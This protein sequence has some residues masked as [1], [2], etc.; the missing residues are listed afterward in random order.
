MGGRSP[1]REKISFIPNALHPDFARAGEPFSSSFV[2]PSRYLL[3]IASQDRPHK[4]LA[5][6]LSI[7]RNLG[8]ARQNVS[9]VIAGQGVRDVGNLPDGVVSRGVVSRSE[10]SELYRSAAGVVIPSRAEGFGFV[11][12]EAHAHGVR[13]L[14][15]PVPALLELAGEGDLVCEDSSE[16]SLEDG[17]VR[18]LATLE[19]NTASA[20]LSAR[21][22]LPSF[23]R[24]MAR[25][26]R[27]VV[28]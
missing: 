6:L 25:L 23:G 22:L 26:Y 7:W 15:R 10:L 21:H 8:S 9:L 16:R 2:L 1:H 14:I 5:E 18:F 19:S 12:L 20:Q 13:C 11:L 3:C 24:E 27:E 17:L 4:G 28:G